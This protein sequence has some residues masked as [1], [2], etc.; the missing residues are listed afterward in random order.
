M[1][2]AFSLLFALPSFLL[3]MLAFG[4]VDVVAGNEDLAELRRLAEQGDADAQYNL[5]VRYDTGERMPKGMPKGSG[6]VFW[7][8]QKPVR[9][10][11]NH[12]INRT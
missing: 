11:G 8:Q 1:P 4:E 3:C 6:L 5:G 2:N 9:F 10:T 12:T 7:C